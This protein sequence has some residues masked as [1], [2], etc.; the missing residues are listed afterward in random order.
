[1]YTMQTLY[2]KWLIMQETD[3]YE[4]LES[5]YAGGKGWEFSGNSGSGCVNTADWYLADIMLNSAMLLQEC[6]QAAQLP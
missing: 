4:W 3:I 1:M 5:F 6:R 2:E